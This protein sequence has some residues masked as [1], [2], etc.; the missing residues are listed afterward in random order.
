MSD[1]GV[2]TLFRP[3]RESYR[4]GAGCHTRLLERCAVNLAP[5]PKTDFHSANSTLHFLVKL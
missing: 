2:L 5:D 4:Q 3:L 1:S